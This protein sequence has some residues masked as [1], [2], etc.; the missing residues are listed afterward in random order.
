MLQ[1]AA[2]L[3]ETDFEQIL[4][5]LVPF[6]LQ[7]SSLCPVL[8]SSVCMLHIIHVCMLQIIHVQHDIMNGFRKY[9]LLTPF[10]KY[11]IDTIY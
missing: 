4:P 3:I 11:F 5:G 1:N 7:F 2:S 10:M 8:T 9:I 6:L